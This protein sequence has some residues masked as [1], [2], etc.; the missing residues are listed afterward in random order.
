[1][2]GLSRTGE[3]LG[4][5]ALINA[6]HYLASKQKGGNMDSKKVLR[7]EDVDIRNQHVTMEYLKEVAT[8]IVEISAGNTEEYCS[9]VM[10]Y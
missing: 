7:K 4:A 6:W 10:K 8:G 9:T 3:A 5:L 2:G 1:M